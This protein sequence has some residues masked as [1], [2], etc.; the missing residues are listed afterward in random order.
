LKKKKNELLSELMAWVSTIEDATIIAFV[1]PYLKEMYFQEAVQYFWGFEIKALI[2]FSSLDTKNSLYQSTINKS[3][4][5]WLKLLISPFI[6]N[7]SKHPPWPIKLT[8]RL[9]GILSKMALVLLVAECIDFLG[10]VPS[11]PYGLMLLGVIALNGSF[12]YLL[13]GALAFYYNKKSSLKAAEPVTELSESFAPLIDSFFQKVVKDLFSKEREPGYQPRPGDLSFLRAFYVPAGVASEQ[14]EM[15]IALPG[16]KIKTHSR[17][18]L[19]LKALNAATNFFV[20]EEKKKSDNKISLGENIIY[21]LTENN[22]YIK[23]DKQMLDRLFKSHYSKQSSSQFIQEVF[24]TVERTPRVD[25]IGEDETRGRKGLYPGCSHKLR[26]N[27]NN[28][29]FRVGLAARPPTKV[30][31]EQGVLTEVYSPRVLTRGHKKGHTI[32]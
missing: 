19:Q 4:G 22:R 27:L 21:L 24:S 31:E 9:Q 23:L 7:S 11:A 29:L 28:S 16:E 26:L 6:D 25:K 30:E 14:K 20:P 13:A 17:P 5:A 2:L 8:Q 1:E 32:R 15:E 3:N 12:N 18:F 10:K